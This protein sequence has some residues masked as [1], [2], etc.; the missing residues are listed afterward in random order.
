MIFLTFYHYILSL[1]QELNLNNYKTHIYCGDGKGKTT[2]S[3]GL[4]I[5]AACA[6]YTIVFTQFLKSMDT[7]EIVIL[8]KIENI[9]VLRANISSKFTFQM[10][11]EE[12]KHTKIEH[13]KMFLYAID[14]LNTFNDSKKM[15]VLD[16][17]FG[18]ISSNTL[19]KHFILDNIKNINAEIVLTGRQPSA[20]FIEIADYVSEIVKVKHPYDAGHQA[21]RGIEF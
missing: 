20:D 3:I 14:L 17:V 1:I 13:E 8:D 16:E 12:L 19:D 4:A 9:S 15:L 18:A 11:E 10:T 21:R 6:G 2:S 5:R 7:S